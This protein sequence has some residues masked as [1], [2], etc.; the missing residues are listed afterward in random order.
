MKS[1][2]AE[3]KCLK[4]GEFRKRHDL[5][6]TVERCKVEIMKA[7][8][9]WFMIVVL[10]FSGWSSSWASSF[11]PVG[12]AH[13]H[14]MHGGMMHSMGVMQ[15]NL[16]AKADVVEKFA[17][18]SKMMSHSGH[19]CCPPDAAGMVIT[20]ASQ[21]D[22]CPYCADQCHCNVDCHAFSHVATLK[23]YVYL[24]LVTQMTVNTS[25][26]AAVPAAPVVQIERPPK[27]V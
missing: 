11:V 9:H 17:V 14:T 27:T 7:F 3:I 19:D 4:G 18:H 25:S 2:M 6:C 13:L 23:N 8:K 24:V 26:N 22:T 10:L 21:T 20:S 1:V 15:A 5:F 16:A 12:H